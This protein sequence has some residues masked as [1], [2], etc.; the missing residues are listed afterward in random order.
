MSPTVPRYGER[1]VYTEPFPNPQRTVAADEE[2]FGGGA[3]NKAIT[4]AATNLNTTLQTKIAEEKEAADKAAAMSA[5]NELAIKSIE[6]DSELRTYKGGDALKTVGKNGKETDI[7]GL[8][9]EKFSDITASVEKKL[10][11]DNQRALFSTIKD[12]Y[13]IRGLSAAHGYFNKERQVFETDNYVNGLSVH[14][15]AIE[16]AAPE[17]HLKTFGESLASKEGLI[18]ERAKKL[19]KGKEWFESE[20]AK[21]QSISYQ[22]SIRALYLTGNLDLAKKQVD[23]AEGKLLTP[24]AKNLAFQVDAK[25]SAQKIVDSKKSSESAFKAVE[26]ISDPKMRKAV[27]EVVK[28]HFVNVDAIKKAQVQEKRDLEEKAFFDGFEL[29]KEGKLTDAWLDE[30]VIDGHLYPKRAQFMKEMNLGTKNTWFGELAKEGDYKRVEDAVAGKVFIDALN[31]MSRGDRRVDDIL[32]KA[33]EDFLRASKDSDIGQKDLFWI[34]QVA[35]KLKAEPE[36]AKVK[37]LAAVANVSR[38]SFGLAGSADFL[39]GLDLDKDV[40]EQYKQF[41][42]RTLAGTAGVM[43]APKYLINAYGFLRKVFDG[44]RKEVSS[45]SDA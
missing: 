23:N 37:N 24:E 34:Y 27:R 4:S 38:K 31:K 28:A 17:N 12:N 41:A 30:Q 16:N 44:D 9:D 22:K 25:F 6:L 39:R 10:R 3:S 33:A 1:K 5:A 32:D 19:G 8:F 7:I 40:Y 36:S 2:T 21:Q 43:E 29:L 18:F 15:L 35:K 13:K 42:D 20:L 14:D 26:A 11:N 45:K